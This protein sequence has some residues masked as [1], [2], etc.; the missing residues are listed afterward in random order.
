[1]FEGGVMSDN[2]LVW[3]VYDRLRTVR[4]NEK[5]YGVR[6]QKYERINFWS[7]IIVALASS[8]SAIA[9]FAFW[10]TATGSEIWKGLLVVSALIATSKPL[11][12]LTKKIKAYEEL[13]SGYR[14]LCHDLKDLKIDINQTQSYSTSHQAT[15]KKIIE[16][17]RV[18]ATKSPERTEKEKVKRTCQ[19]EV[20]SEFPTNTFYVPE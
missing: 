10:S 6:L 9:G 20:L 15:F 11:L 12:N 18:L 19:D 3:D 8:S 16:K 5:Y 17:Q 4:L 7:E 13:L 1:M 2:H 14:L